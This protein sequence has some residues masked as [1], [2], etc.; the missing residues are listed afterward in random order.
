MDAINTKAEY[1]AIRQMNGMTYKLFNI[2]RFMALE[3][4]VDENG[5]VTLSHAK[6]SAKLGIG[7]NVTRILSDLKLFPEFIEIKQGDVSRP[8]Q[9]KVNEQFLWKG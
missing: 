6:I 4:N 9:F 5:Y 1:E 8:N 2:I 7:N 3:G